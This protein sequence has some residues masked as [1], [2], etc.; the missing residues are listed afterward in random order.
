M[1]EIGEC[2]PQL[3]ILKY[4]RALE[5]RGRTDRFGNQ[6]I[7]RQQRVSFRDQMT[8]EP[9]SSVHIVEAHIY[10]SFRAGA[11]SGCCQVF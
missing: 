5:S 3:P 11:R 9:I 8:K 2:S 10:E 7:K 6:F 1:E 4:K